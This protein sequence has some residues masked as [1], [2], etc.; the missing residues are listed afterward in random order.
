[1]ERSLTLTF[2]TSN[3]S[4]A[5][6]TI[7]GV[8]DGLTKEQVKALMDVIIANNIFLTKNGSLLSPSKAKVTE[9]SSRDMI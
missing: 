2:V 1:M 5:T 8:K 6:L 7:Q 4:K 3:G 9:K